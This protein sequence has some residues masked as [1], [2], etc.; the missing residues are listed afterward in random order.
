MVELLTEVTIEEYE[1]GIEVVTFR[2]GVVEIALLTFGD[3]EVVATST[4]ELDISEITVEV[5]ALEEEVT[6]AE[7]VVELTVVSTTGADVGRVVDV[8]FRIDEDGTSET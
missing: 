6:K 4:V 8:T 1:D 7:V 3:R 2:T 5:T